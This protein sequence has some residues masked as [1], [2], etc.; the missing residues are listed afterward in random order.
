MP[1]MPLLVRLISGGYVRNGE[2]GI[3]GRFDSSGYLRDA[4]GNTI[5]RNPI[6]RN[7]ALFLIFFQ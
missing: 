6:D 1:A 2:G 7:L 4:D 5:T 3:I